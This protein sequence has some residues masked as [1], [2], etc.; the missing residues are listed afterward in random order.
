MNKN[1]YKEW[2]L[3]HI[4]SEQECG[5]DMS[6]GNSL[7][8]AIYMIDDIIVYGCFVGGQRSVDHEEIKVD[9]V[10]WEDILNWG[11]IVV[12]ETTSYISDVEVDELEEIGF[13][14]LP[15]NSNHIVGFKGG[16]SC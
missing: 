8:E 5:W 10:T 2:L 16:V 11:T 13:D 1:E 15:L 4:L 6:Y 9:E 7:S 12:P 3:N 14:R